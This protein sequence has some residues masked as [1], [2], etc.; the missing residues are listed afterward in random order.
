MQW[1]HKFEDIAID[2]MDK[3]HGKFTRTFK[4]AYF[5]KIS[6]FVGL[7]F[8]SLHP[9]WSYKPRCPAIWQQNVNDNYEYC[10]EKINTEAMR[11]CPCSFSSLKSMYT[12]HP[13]VIFATDSHAYTSV[14]VCVCKYLCFFCVRIV[15]ISIWSWLFCGRQSVFALK[16]TMA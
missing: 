1:K 3:K 12:W 5:L 11:R 15:Y 9:S 14:C 6:P 7:C 13:Q 10:Y 2:C 4:H 16:K 8:K